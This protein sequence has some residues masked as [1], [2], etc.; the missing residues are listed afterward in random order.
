MR[1]VTAWLLVAE[2]AVDIATACPMHALLHE[3]GEP[4]SRQITSSVTVANRINR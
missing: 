4:G 2:R 1:P 3:W